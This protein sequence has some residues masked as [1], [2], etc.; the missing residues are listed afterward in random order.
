ME[1]C[2]LTR[3]AWCRVGEYGWFEGVTSASRRLRLTV[4]YLKKPTISF[5]KA[6]KSFIK[7]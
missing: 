6:Y 3:G 5:I 4:N 2:P 7:A 1:R